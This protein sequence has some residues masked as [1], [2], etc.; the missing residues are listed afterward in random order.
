MSKRKDAVK[1]LKHLD[2]KC[3]DCNSRK[4]VLIQRKK[5]VE[6]VTYIKKYIYCLLCEYEVEYKIKGQKEKI[7][8]EET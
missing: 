2:K 4:L 3:P 5:I 6:G 1:A 7:Q 8:F